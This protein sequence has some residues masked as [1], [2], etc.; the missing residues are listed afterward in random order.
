MPLSEWIWMWLAPCF[1]KRLSN[2]IL[3]LMTQPMN[4]RFAILSLCMR[5]QLMCHVLFV[6]R[7]K[8]LDTHAKEAALISTSLLTLWH[9]P[10]A[11]FETGLHVPYWNSRLTR[12]VVH[13]CAGLERW[14]L[15]RRRRG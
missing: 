14:T 15:V 10:T 12:H 6:S 5:C 9:I 11:L 8:A 1:Q 3:G 7:S 2:C 13:V 4:V